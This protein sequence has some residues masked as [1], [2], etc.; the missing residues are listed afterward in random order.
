MRF[1]LVI[2]ISIFAYQS[3]TM[4]DDIRD[5]QIEGISIGDTLLAYMNKNE[6]KNSDNNYFNN[7]KYNSVRLNITP[8]NFDYLEVAFL[9]EDK[10]FLIQGIS[11]LTLYENNHI[12]C[13]NDRLSFIKDIKDFFKKELDKKNAE[14]IEGKRNHT[15]HLDGD[16]LVHYFAIRFIKTKDFIVIS[17][18]DIDPKDDINGIDHM[19]ADVYTSEYDYFL[20]HVAYK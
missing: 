10:N 14:I 9:S 13:M 20:V 3:L 6:I 12:Q 5:F 7:K 1:I 2:L 17:C 4:A 19:R 8:N 11:G 16:S 18:I 15:A